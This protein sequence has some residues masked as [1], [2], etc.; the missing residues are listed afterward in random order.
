MGLPGIRVIL[1]CV[2]DH[3]V[4]VGPEGEGKFAGVLPGGPETALVCGR[5]FIHRVEYQQ[6][7]FHRYDRRS[8]HLRRLCL[9]VMLG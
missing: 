8:I 1:S 6:R 3:R 5:L 4:R 2:V 7:A 9:Y